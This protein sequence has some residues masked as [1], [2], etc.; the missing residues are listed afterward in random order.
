MDIVLSVIAI[1][2]GAAVPVWLHRREN[3]AREIRYGVESSRLIDLAM[4]D[5]AAP[6]VRFYG[7]EVS[8][9]Y[10]ATVRV[11]SA[12]R[13]DVPSA[14]FDSGKP[15]VVDMGAPIIAG[16]FRSGTSRTGLSF[17]QLS[18]CEVGIGPGLLPKDFDLTF[19]ALL[20]VQPQVSIRSPLI[21]VAVVPEHQPTT[22]QVADVHI[23]RV[24]RKARVTGLRVITA[25]TIAAAVLLVVAFALYQVEAKVSAAVGGVAIIVLGMCAVAYIAI[26]LTRFAKFVGA[27]ARGRGV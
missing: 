8:D 21:E 11:W 9:P 24:R 12:G 5:G 7:R 1:I 15:L 14:A 3:P 26:G 4:T 18:D 16:T 2:I 10:K 20:E 23:Q 6:S 19:E 17:T 25:I 22:A 13:A 27:L